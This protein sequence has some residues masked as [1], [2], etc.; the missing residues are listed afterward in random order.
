MPLVAFAWRACV[1]RP[2]LQGQVP[3]LCL[4]DTVQ[5]GLAR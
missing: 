3:G 1:F 2:D 5:A 4:G